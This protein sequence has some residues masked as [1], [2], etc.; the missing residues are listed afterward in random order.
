MYC[1]NAHFEIFFL[2]KTLFKFV[3]KAFILS[4][5]LRKFKELL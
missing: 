5:S 2:K 1:K 3:L 4:I